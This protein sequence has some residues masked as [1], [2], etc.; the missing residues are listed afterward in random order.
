MRALHLQTGEE[1]VLHTAMAEAGHDLPRAIIGP[2]P[3]PPDDR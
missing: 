3:D 1:A 2:I